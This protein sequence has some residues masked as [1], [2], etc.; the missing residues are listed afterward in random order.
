MLDMKKLRRHFDEVKRQLAKRGELK[1]IDKFTELDVQRRELLQQSEQ[2][3]GTE[4][5][6]PAHCRKEEK[7]RTR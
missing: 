5:R 1:E 6:F 4:C 3:K 7:G 2:F